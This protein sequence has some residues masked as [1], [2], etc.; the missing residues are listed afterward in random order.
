MGLIYIMHT[1]CEKY[2]NRCLR[3]YFLWG[4]LQAFPQSNER[5]ENVQRIKIRAHDDFIKGG[6]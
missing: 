4:V 2:H 1:C 6:C 5:L 3:H